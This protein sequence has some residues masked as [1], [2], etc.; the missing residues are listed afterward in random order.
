MTAPL[1]RRDMLHLGAGTAAAIGASTLTDIGAQGVAAQGRPAAAVPPT[2][3]VSPGVR[4][5]YRD[6]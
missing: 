2:I 4:L 1:S 6:D 5:F 3:E